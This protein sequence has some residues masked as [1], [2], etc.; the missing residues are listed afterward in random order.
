MSSAPEGSKQSI[1]EEKAVDHPNK[2]GTSHQS[3]LGPKAKRKHFFAP[4]DPAY[5]DAVNKDAEFVEFTADEEVWLFITSMAIFELTRHISEPSERRLTPLYFLWSFAGSVGGL[6]L[7]YIVTD[8]ELSLATFVSKFLF[9]RRPDA[10]NGPRK[11]INLV[12]GLLASL[13][14]Q[15]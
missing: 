12:R 13:L 7:L 3:E 11:S 9:V 1:E 2:E 10:H 15:S 14:S 4:L 5:A 6:Q 8:S